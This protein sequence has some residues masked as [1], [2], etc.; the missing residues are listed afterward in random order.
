MD[1]T[2]LRMSSEVLTMRDSEVF[3]RVA[4]LS[5][6]A[7]ASPDGTATAIATQSRRAVETRMGRIPPRRPL[8]VGS[9]DR[10]AQLPPWPPW[11]RIGQSRTANIATQ[12]AAAN[13]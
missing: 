8:W 3:L 11:Q 4:S 1:G 10:K 7:A 12:H 2:P 6:M 5:R 9:P 13:G